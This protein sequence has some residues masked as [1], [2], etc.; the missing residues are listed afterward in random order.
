MSGG[1]SSSRSRPQATPEQIVQL[2]NKYLP[3][4][5]GTTVGQSPLTASALTN[6]TVGNSP[7]FSL[8]NLSQL[9]GLSPYFTQ[10]GNQV[11]Q[12]Q[13]AGTADLLSGQ[14]ARAA[15]NAEALTRAINPEYYAA[16]TN[17]GG[18]TANLLG[19]Y[20]ANGA[21]S[22]AEQAAAERGLAI[23]NSA[24]GN[25]GNTSA[26]STIT[27]AMYFGDALRQKQASMANAVNAG[28][29]A[30][31]TMQNNQFNPV[32]VALNAGNTGGNFALQFLNPTQSNQMA[33]QFATAPLDFG[34]NLFGGLAGIGSA[35]K[36]SG[37]SWNAGVAD[38]CFIFLESYNGTLP[39]FVRDC[40]DYY[41]KTYPEVAAGYKKMAKWLVPLMRRSRLVAQLVNKLM[42]M[43][44]TRYGGWVMGVRGYEH[45][46]KCRWAKN[47]WFKVWSK[48]S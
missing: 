35:S 43:P 8:S 10:I 20:G 41:Y 47:F 14:G 1:A 2:Y 39:W 5:L 46:E 22:P 32:G 44:L 18:A 6:T 21:L 42:I 31:N 15:L 19:S 30:I 16:R 33:S 13:A 36:G 23:N 7:A 28:S 25:L 24:T 26:L 38:C 40:R 12:Q 9:A 34:S 27:N 29:N 17:L 45:Y 3:E 37:S 48:L 4:T 11:A